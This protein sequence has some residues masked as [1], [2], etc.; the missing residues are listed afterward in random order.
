M[1]INGTAIIKVYWAEVSRLTPVK[2]PPA[3]LREVGEELFQPRQLAA[4]SRLA[5]GV[6]RDP[7]LDDGLE[8]FCEF[9]GGF[10]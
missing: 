1:N 10:E 9:H 8:K 7:D 2:S 5:A 4:D 6:G 3:A